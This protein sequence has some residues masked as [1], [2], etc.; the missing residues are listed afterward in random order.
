MWTLLLSLSLLLAPARADWAP[1]ARDQKAYSKGIAA[2]GGSSLSEAEAAFKSVLARDPSC[3]MAQHGLALTLLRQGRLEEAKAALDAA[4]LAFPGQVEVLVALSEL[5]FVRQDFDAARSYA[6]KAVS[7]D[8]GSIEAHAT[9]QQVYLR[10]AELTAARADI[11]A[12]RAEL[13]DPV[14][15][16]FEVQLAAEAGDSATAEARLPA[17]KNAAT[18]DL[19]AAAIT[20]V[21]G[22]V[23][24]VGTVA[25]RLGLDRMVVLAQAVDH[26]NEYDWAAVKTVLEPL[27]KERPD[28]VQALLLRGRAREMS[29]DRAG[30]KADYTLGLQGKPWIDLHQNGTMTGILTASDEARLREMMGDGA[31]QLVVFLIEARDYSAAEKR[32]GEL[33]GSMGDQ[34]NLAAATARLRLAQGKGAEAGAAVEGGLAGWPG[35]FRLL[36]AAGLLATTSPQHLGPKAREALG[37]STDSADRYNLAFALRK[38][39]D[40]EGCLSTVGAALEE[41]K[42]QGGDAAKMSVMGHGCAVD[43]GDLRRSDLLFAQTTGAKVPT[44]TRYNHALMRKKAN[45]GAGALALIAEALQAPAS[46]NA[47]LDRGIAGLGL[48]IYVEQGDW[49]GALRVATRPGTS[50]TDLYWFGS[51]LAEAERREDAR[52]VL[53][54]ACPRL[55]GAEQGRCS[56]MLERLGG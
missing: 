30:A 4:I 42:L 7:A 52:R 21:G 12:A 9:L 13:P 10:T 53:G 49:T 51:K 3:G 14:I 5:A 47:D 16:C 45:D 48:R 44:V 24:S 46:D 1:Q 28:D 6:K 40:A 31:G 25:S 35:H 19:I 39:G 41:L 22:R 33:K 34:A 54:S 32:L 36:Q 15:A 20:R 55:E 37:R 11:E 38:A 29:G 23:D 26:A 2:L 27:L 18:F 56:A 50:P 43:L 8:P 17:C